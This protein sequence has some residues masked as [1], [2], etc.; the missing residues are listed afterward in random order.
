MTGRTDE[1][2]YAE[3]NR[4]K[5]NAE[6]A[7]SDAESSDCVFFPDGYTFILQLAKAHRN[8]RR[9][10]A[11]NFSSSFATLFYDIKRYTYVIRLVP[12]GKSRPKFFSGFI[13]LRMLPDLQ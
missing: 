3:V 13:D 8:A 6:L 10:R 2:A 11:F 1:R 5:K 7:F 12:I 4:Y 9:I